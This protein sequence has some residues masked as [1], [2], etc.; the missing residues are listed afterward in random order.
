MALLCF[1]LT[2]LKNSKAPEVY[3]VAFANIFFDLIDKRIYDQ[4]DIS[5]LNA[6]LANDLLNNI[7]LSH[8][9]IAG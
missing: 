9:A 8:S 1:A 6:G 3:A 2:W 4:V 7:T 5:C